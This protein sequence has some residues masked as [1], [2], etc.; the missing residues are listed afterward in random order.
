MNKNND[1]DL[2]TDGEL[3]ADSIQM[4]G[5]DID[6]DGTRSAMPVDDDDSLFD[7]NPMAW[8]AKRRFDKEKL[9]YTQFEKEED[10]GIALSRGFVCVTRREA[11]FS[12]EVITEFGK[13]GTLDQAHHVGNMYLI[14][15]PWAM[16]EKIEVQRRKIARAATNPIL[17]A[18]SK[19]TKHPSTEGNVITEDESHA[20]VTAARMSGQ[21]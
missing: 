18:K 6:A 15:C 21:P 13:S 3:H 7:S 11:G 5:I 19:Q 12:N 20:H 9:W 17:L 8:P 14:K 10:L 16:H 4:P 1:K 2:N